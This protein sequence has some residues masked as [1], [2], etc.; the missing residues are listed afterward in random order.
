M[1]KL[2]DLKEIKLPKYEHGVKY[3]SWS[4]KYLGAAKE[5]SRAKE[6]LEGTIL[7]KYRTAKGNND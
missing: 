2:E 6:C 4:K 1:S 7:E 3:A 5:R